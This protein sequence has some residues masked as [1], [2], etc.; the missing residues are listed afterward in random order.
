MQACEITAIKISQVCDVKV[1]QVLRMM[2]S[3]FGNQSR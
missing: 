2:I 1:Q 3:S